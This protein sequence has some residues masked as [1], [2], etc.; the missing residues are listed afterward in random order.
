MHLKPLL[1]GVSGKRGQVP[2][3]SLLV[4]NSCSS[5]FDP[6]LDLL[7][8]S[9][10]WD[11]AVTHTVPGPPEGSGSGMRVRGIWRRGRWKQHPGSAIEPEARVG[12]EALGGM[13]FAKWARLD[14]DMRLAMFRWAGSVG[15]CGTSQCKALVGR[16]QGPLFSLSWTLCS[17]LCLLR[18]SVV[19]AN[20]GLLVERKARLL[21]LEDS[22]AAV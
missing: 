20:T 19:P 17:S 11:V 6:G 16:G 3:A 1:G 12:Q 5:H 14:W 7:A 13:A 8:P 21:V 4:C 18:H 22:S 9:R 2:P 15:L 10:E